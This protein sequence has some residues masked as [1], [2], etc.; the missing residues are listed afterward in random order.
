MK[1]LRLV[2][3]LDALSSKDQSYFHPVVRLLSIGHVAVA[4]RGVVLLL[5]SE[6]PAFRSFLSSVR[7]S[8]G[9]PI[10]VMQKQD[11]RVG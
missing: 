11:F 10:R 4:A 6:A 9:R 5:S 3:L 2:N 1:R 8:Q 7:Q